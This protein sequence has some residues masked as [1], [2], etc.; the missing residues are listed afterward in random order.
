MKKLPPRKW[1]ITGAVAATAVALSAAIWLRTPE[2]PSTSAPPAA[3]PP[4]TVNEPTQNNKENT[5]AIFVYETVARPEVKIGTPL[6]FKP[7]VSAQSTPLEGIQA[8][9]TRKIFDEAGYGSKFGTSFA[10][11]KEGTVYAWGMKGWNFYSESQSYPIAIHG[12]PKVKQ[13]EGEFAVTDAGD[14]WYINFGNAPRAI[15]ELKGAVSIHQAANDS[16]YAL[17]PDGTVWHWMLEGEKQTPKLQQI[18]SLAGIERLYVGMFRIIAVQTDGTVLAAGEDFGHPVQEAPSKLTLPDGGELA[19][20]DFTMNNQ[21]AY[22]LTTKGNWYE[23]RYDR[24]KEL[25]P[26]PEWGSFTKV[27]GSND[28]VFALHKD[29]SLWGSGPITSSSQRPGG[30]QTN[31]KLEPM[32]G[33]SEIIDFTNG[34]DHIL[35]LRK[36]GTVMTWGSNMFGQLGRFPYYSK[37]FVTV[38][39]LQGA[40]ALF[41]VQ[42]GLAAI[43][44]GN[45]WSF[46]PANEQ[47][48]PLLLGMNI[49]KVAQQ[50]E[51][52]VFLSKDGA[53]YTLP[54]AEGSMLGKITSQGGVITNLEGGTAGQLLVQLE[55]GDVYEISLSKQG[56]DRIRQ[57]K[58]EAD[59]VGKP[60]QLFDQPVAM[61]VM[62]DGRVFYRERETETELLMKPIPDIPAVKEMAILYNTYDQEYSFLTHVLDQAGAVHEVRIIVKQEGNKKEDRTVSFKIKKNIA[63]A[64]AINR[65]LIV[66]ADGAL[67]ERENY[68]KLKLEGKLTSPD[69]LK[70]IASQYYF[71]IEG[72]QSFYHALLLQDGTVQIGGFSPLYRE[73]AKPGLVVTGK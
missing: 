36:D 50:T 1:L 46:N 20:A 25:V 55:Q 37:Q 15:P 28:S 40:D 72:P 29:G 67:T 41:P 11:S 30:E 24:N 59:K 58:F 7:S 5:G 31:R 8:V 48:K 35:A 56:I 17:K 34:S 39:K 57:L 63:Q 2:Q 4:V 62:D 12:L 47:Q 38:G 27:S 70:S 73:A 45:V 14:I 10:L 43:A 44:N 18:S 53:I 42:G 61:V 3:E 6:A 9:S 60:V 22:L 64:A 68:L 52:P 26:M 32:E 51:F 33:V 65:G 49:K 13:V 66:N 71:Y 21:S 16:I 54:D 19:R 23:I 69:E